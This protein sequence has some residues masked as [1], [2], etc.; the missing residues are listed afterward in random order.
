LARPSTGGLALG[1]REGLFAAGC[2]RA[3]LR[4]R[5]FPPLGF[6]Y[7]A[8]GDTICGAL[9]V[10]RAI[11]GARRTAAATDNWLRQTISKATEG[12]ARPV[13]ATKSEALSAR[14]TADKPAQVTAG[15]NPKS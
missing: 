13:A 5:P 4:R 14:T 9:L 3:I 15:K 12:L 1:C 10:V 6:S 7:F 11:N 2:I 8:A